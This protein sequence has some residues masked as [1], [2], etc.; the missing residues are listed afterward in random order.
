MILSVKNY[1]ERQNLQFLQYAEACKQSGVEPQPRG[2]GYSTFETCPKKYG[3]VKPLYAGYVWA[4]TKKALQ[5]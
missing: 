3:Y 1:N 4:R 5:R 2:T